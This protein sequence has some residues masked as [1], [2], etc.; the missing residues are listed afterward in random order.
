M[1][2]FHPKNVHCLLLKA[3]VAQPLHCFPLPDQL[4][5]ASQA[6]CSKF[7]GGR[8]ATIEGLPSNSDGL[9][10]SNSGRPDSDDSLFFA[11]I[12]SK[13]GKERAFS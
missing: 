4:C 1:L 13:Q 2:G 11:A 10:A 5:Y 12:E 9:S 7:I 3:S 6:Q 8:Q